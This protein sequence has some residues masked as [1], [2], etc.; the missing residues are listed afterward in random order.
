MFQLLIDPVAE[1]RKRKKQ[2]YSTVLLYLIAAALFETVGLLFFAMRLET[3]LPV[4]T[5]DML[6]LG[7]VGTLIL[8]VV[9]HFV[10]AL[11]FAIAMHVLDGKGGYY[12]ALTSLVL[13]FVAPAVAVFFSG[14]LSF[15]P[16]GEFAAVFLVTLG[17]VM[18]LATLL[19][20]AKEFFQIS[21]AGVLAGCL[22]TF[23]P[24]LLAGYTVVLLV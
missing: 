19:R 6:M 7:I 12:E 2:S 5:P 21:Y 15:I 3:F 23:M 1:I 13:A 10:I 8:L 20:S 17:C 9:C 14:A 22:I 4:F 24:L 16:L 18:G 11:F